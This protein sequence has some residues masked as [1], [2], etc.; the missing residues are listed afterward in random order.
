MRLL[1]GWV[2]IYMFFTKDYANDKNL[3]PNQFESAAPSMQ[4]VWPSTFNVL[5]VIILLLTLVVVRNMLTMFF[6]GLCPSDSIR[7]LMESSWVNYLG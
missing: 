3:A 2:I 6:P 7:I 4:V 1:V 5:T